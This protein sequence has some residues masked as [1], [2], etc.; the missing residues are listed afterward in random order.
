MYLCKQLFRSRSS[1]PQKEPR[2]SGLELGSENECKREGEGEEEGHAQRRSI[3]YARLG[4]S[5]LHSNPLAVTG[6][7]RS[8]TSLEPSAP[9]ECV[10]SPS[11]LREKSSNFE[12]PSNILNVSE[13]VTST[14]FPP[15]VTVPD[16]PSSPTNRLS[17]ES[18]GGASSPPSPDARGSFRFMH[19][20]SFQVGNHVHDFIISL[21]MCLIL[22]CIRMQLFRS[23][24]SSPQK[25]PRECA[26]GIELGSDEECK[27][28]GEGEGEEEGHAQRRS[29]HYARLGRSSL[30]SNPL[31]AGGGRR[32]ITSTTH[33]STADRGAEEREG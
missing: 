28:E 18:I 13:H 8:M 20:N 27:R 3:H 22:L 21:L 31:A 17:M 2:E 32:S 4:R 11:R 5:S 23:R 19:E 16:S 6:G 30:H 15:D 1:S 25:E 7:R 10:D 26:P 12:D 9:G 14:I 33:I 29:I 24:S